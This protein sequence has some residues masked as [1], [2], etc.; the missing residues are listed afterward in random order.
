MYE[1]F[2]QNF[3]KFIFIFVLF[4]S[5]S[6]SFFLYKEKEFN[7]VI[8]LSLTYELLSLI[9]KLNDINQ[10]YFSQ[11]VN[12][13]NGAD[14]FDQLYFI[15]RNE[16]KILKNDIE[17]KIIEPDQYQKL[18]VY[19]TRKISII[20]NSSNIDDLSQSMDEYINNSISN[21]RFDLIGEL[22]S[23]SLILKTIDESSILGQIYE[24]NNHFYSIIFEAN[25]LTEYINKIK[26]VEISPIDNIKSN[27]NYKQLLFYLLLSS[28]FSIILITLYSSLKMKTK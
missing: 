22:I 27:K 17:I 16:K 14:Q 26:L 11:Q 25:N 1:F 2:K 7:K 9:K 12:N 15:L 8:N 3:F 21:F 18:P 13:A 28:V 6:L 23:K 4:N 24:S 10:I 19:D 5:L 20:A